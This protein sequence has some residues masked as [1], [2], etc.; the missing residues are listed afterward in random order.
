MKSSTAW[1]NSSGRSMLI[2][3]PPQAEQVRSVAVERLGEVVGLLGLD[4]TEQLD[5]AL[6]IHLE[7]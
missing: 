6:R 2:E 7:L 5:K 4:L 3:C 1:S